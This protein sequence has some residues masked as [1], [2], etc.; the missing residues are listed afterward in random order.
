M[1]KFLLK[2]IAILIVAWAGWTFGWLLAV[3]LTVPYHWLPSLIVPVARF[4]FALGAVVLLSRAEVNIRVNTQFLNRGAWLV[5]LSIW[6]SIL[7]LAIALGGF[8][9]ISPWLTPIVALLL[10]ALYLVAV[11]LIVGKLPINTR[12]RWPAVAG[13][14][15]LL[16]LVPVAFELISSGFGYKPGKAAEQ[17]HPLVATFSLRDRPVTGR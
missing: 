12:W 8:D 4:G 15:V 14:L 11:A 6:G 7:S 3:A 5:A 2:L 9:R 16:T 17:K 13:S 10:G 1:S